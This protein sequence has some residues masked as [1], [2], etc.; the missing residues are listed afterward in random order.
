MI[1]F[2]C[3]YNC[4]CADEILFALTEANKSRQIT[5]GFDPYCEKAKEKIKKAVRNENADIYFLV[6]G[7]QTNAEALSY[8]LKGYEGVLCAETGHIAVHEAGAVE[9][10]THKVLPVKNGEMG[11]I[12]I[13]ALRKWLV[14]FYN[15]GSYPH[16]VQPGAVYI[17]HPTEYG[18][19]YSKKEIEEIRSICDEYKLVLYL[20]GARLA[21]ALESED[22]DVTL[23]DLGRLCDAFYIGGTK[24]GSLMGE[25]LVFREKAPMFFTHR[26]RA[27]G[28]LAKGYLL[29]LQFDVLFTD[30]LYSRL[31]KNAIKCA[32]LL[33]KGLKEKNVHFF[34]D[35]PTN[36]QFVILNNEELKKLDG[37]IGYD[38]WEKRENETVIRF[39]TS[40]KS[41]EDEINELIS[42]F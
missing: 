11:K 22:T 16:M 38:V 8:F 19:L 37:K 6:G 17:S 13:A 31:G 35:S 15:D 34:C 39:C 27:G 5:Y 1:D 3:D 33:K 29:G 20:D 4:G 41:T 32:M 24:C 25:A 12:D 30:N 14:T 18:G 10:T 28:L 21:Y 42:L 23:A 40:W 26:K 2:S 7:T 36:Q 9:A